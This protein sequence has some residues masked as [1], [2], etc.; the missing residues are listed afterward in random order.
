[1]AMPDGYTA[2]RGH[3]VATYRDWKTWSEN[4]FGHCDKIGTC[5]FERELARAGIHVGPDTSV[6]EVGFGNGTFAAWATARQADYTGTELDPVLVQRAGHHGWRAFP[7]TLALDTLDLP[8]A[9]DCVVLFD[10]LEHLTIAE[11]TELLTSARQVLADDGLLLARFPSG[12]S[13]FARPTQYGDI[14]HQSILGSSAVQQLAAAAGMEVVQTRSPVLPVR[15]I[16][17]RRALRRAPI[18]A[19]RALVTPMIRLTFHNNHPTVITANMIAV[20]RKQRR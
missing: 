13:P 9:P 11:I 2:P 17:L 14:T 5:Y 6:L 18:I 4:D 16:G 1:M 8:R 12:D 20:L 7:A 15:G 19:A 10:V 3:S